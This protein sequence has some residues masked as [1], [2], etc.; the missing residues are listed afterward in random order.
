MTTTAKD[1]YK[2]EAFLQPEL[3]SGVIELRRLAN[4]SAVFDGRA[5]ATAKFLEG[6]N[7]SRSRITA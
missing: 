5:R 6:F 7:Q 2:G 1:Q 3:S 4:L